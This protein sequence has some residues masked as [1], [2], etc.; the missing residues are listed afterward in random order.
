MGWLIYKKDWSQLTR[1]TG[2]GNEE[3]NDN[4]WK[5][6][7]FSGQTSVCVARRL[8]EAADIRN[9]SRNATDSTSTHCTALYSTLLHCTALH[10]TERHWAALCCNEPHCTALH[11]TALHCT[12]LHCTALHCTA[13]H[14]TALGT[15]LHCTALHWSLQCT[16][17]GTGHWAPL[18][19]DTATLQVHSALGFIRHK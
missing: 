4:F 17:L 5:T 6:P 12:A 8:P 10:C 3:K 18:C 11:C 16:S 13:L 9:I 15:A 1:S 19:K 2:S 7:F 14:C